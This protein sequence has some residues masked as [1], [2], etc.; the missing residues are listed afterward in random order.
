MI[1]GVF[2]SI[3]ILSIASGIEVSDEQPAQS[4][5]STSYEQPSLSSPLLDDYDDSS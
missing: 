4:Q 3:N 1:P 5:P 2:V